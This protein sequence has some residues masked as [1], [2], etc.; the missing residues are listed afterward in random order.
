MSLFFNKFEFP[1]F[2]NT[3]D[4][5]QSVCQREI[6][7][8]KMNFDRKSQNPAFKI[9][10]PAD[11]RAEFGRKKPRKFSPKGDIRLRCY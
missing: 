1:F 6:F 9:E 5:L 4:I 7:H 11:K 3:L 2:L 10:N 8:W